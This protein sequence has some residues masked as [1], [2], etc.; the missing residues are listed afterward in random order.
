MALILVTGATGFIGNY[1]VSDL[2]AKG[3]E[4]IATSANA[5]K[6]S[7]MEWFGKVTY[8][9]L[10]FDHIHPGVN[11][12]EYFDNPGAIIHLAWEG[13]PN[14]KS[15]FHFEINLPRHYFFLKN[16]VE[17]GCRNV[18]VAG[19][20]L[21]YGMKDGCLSEDIQTD[22]AN[23]YA[24]AKDTL[25]KFL[26]ELSKNDPF[27]LKWVRLFY[28]F[29]KGQNPG[30]LFSQ[31]QKAL[32][33]NVKEFNMSSGEQVRDYLPVERAAEYIVKIALQNNITGNINCCS[34]Q[35]VTIKEMVTDYMQKSGKKLK[36]NLGYYPYPDYEPMSFWGDNKKL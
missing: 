3:H 2:L 16:L 33:S 25:N 27:T 7:K 23:P 34:A 26:Y 20:C 17:N 35:P 14:Y 36:L 29:G 6:A 1:V 13:L 30:S 8:R 10:P 12:F 18:T 19:T 24:L 15:L 22:P 21:E 4:V 31:L 9:E 32:D 5:N 28:L 11:Y